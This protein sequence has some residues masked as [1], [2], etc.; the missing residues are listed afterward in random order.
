MI[1]A[2][3]SKN[4]FTFILLWI[5]L[6]LVP[7][8]AQETRGSIGGRVTDSTGAV[9]PGAK[10]VATNTQTNTASETTVTG[11]GNFT[12]LYLLPGAY[13][14]SV[15]AQGF[16]RLVRT[17]IELRVADRV[18]IDLQLELGGVTETVNVSGEA[19]LLEVSSA[20]AGQVIDRRR[21]SELPLA[22]GN[23]LTLI[24]LAPGIVITGGFTSNSALSNSGPSNF[25]SGGSPG[26]NEFTLDGSPNTAD[27]QGNGAA[28]VGL[29]PPTD[30]V[31]EF[32]V[33]TASFDAQQGRTAGA[34]IDVAVRSGTN[35]LHG[36]L[37]EFVRNDKL[38]AN[39][40]FLNR[41]GTPRQTR[42][43]NRFGG[44]VGGPIVLPKIYNGRN[45]TFFFTSYEGIRPITPSLE[46]L[47][48]PTDAF[49][50]GDF[51]SLLNL[52]TPLYVYDPA[53]AR[54][55]GARVVREPIQCN[56]RLNVICP[57][58]LSPVA[59]NYLS[60]LPQP[61]T[62]VGSSTNNFVGN[63]SPI[64]TYNVFLA[65]G[66][67]H[68][69]ERNRLFF[70][71]SQSQR[72][73]LDENSA[74]VN[75]GVRINGR[76]GHRGN[77]GGVFDYVYVPSATTV[78]NLRA[79]MT[80]FKQD[81]FSMSSFDYDVRN[82]GFSEQTLRLFTANTLPQINIGN[83]S[84][85]VE[86]TG[87]LITTPTWSLQ[88]TLT[89]VTGAHAIRAGYDFRVY[90]E[91][92]RDQTF[93]AGQ[94]NFNNDFTR[95]NDQNPSIPLEQNQAQSIAALLLGVPTGGNFPLLADRAAT[96]KYH[97]VFVQDDWK[98]SRRLTLNLGLRYELDLGTTERYNRIVAGFDR[99]AANPAEAAVRANYAL[100][101]I[102]EIAAADFRLPGGLRFADEDD[103][104]A[105]RADRNNFQPRI[106]V[107]YQL[108][109]RTAIRGGW[110]MFM[111]PFV[112]DALNQNG[113]TRSTP[114]IAS[115]DRGLTFQS[116]LANPFPSGYVAEINRGLDSLVGQNPGT[117][118]TGDRKNGMVQRWEVSLQRELPG[119]W[120]VEAA[121]I[122]NRGY[123][124]LTAV[125]ANPIFRQF[126]STSPVRDQA[127]INLL[128][129][130]VTNPFRNVPAFL[131]TNLYTATVI[132]RSQ[133]LRPFPQYTG[134]AEERYDGKS[135]Y[136]AG[137]VRLEKRFSRGYTILGSYAWS[138]YLEE[139]TLLNPTDAAY[140]KRLSEFDS[141]HR[142]AISGIYE[143][144]FGRG[145]AFG[146]NWKGLTEAL[147]GGFQV[148]GIYQFQAG[149]PLTIG[150]VYFNGNLS[151]LD[152]KIAS[153]TIGGVG[154]TN[155]LDNTFQRDIR[156]TGFY[157]TD[158]T[159]RT[160]GQLDVAKQR[161]DAR[162]N[163]GNNIRTLP[164]RASNF[165]DDSISLLDV[166]LIKNFA[167][168][169]RVKLQARAEAINSLNKAHFSGPNINP[170]DIAF[171]RVTNLDGPT[172]PREFQIGLRL[173]F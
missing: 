79:G 61:N 78:F 140:E 108:N 141:P 90:Q 121:Y 45:K 102:P 22:E 103:R 144:P 20:T 114:L 148:Q 86:P 53:T 85:P 57:D 95:L 18:S 139:A 152:M 33:V 87:Y 31:E 64:N 115:P 120:L 163:L 16:K 67:H 4:C 157:F 107:A 8:T 149:R 73:E 161:N 62:N 81:R 119:R 130:P 5:G 164:S 35:E 13:S 36:T 153:D 69:N 134:I 68:I 116:T 37:Y 26:G 88:P 113:F 40:F 92:R 143:L 101:P 151:D 47:T 147:F 58:R 131:G 109:D 128:D 146:S 28:R 127:L 100:N 155:I 123:D 169:E 89:K 15:E 44:T 17:G 136:H 43:Y 112:L 9:V 154:T 2:M 51:S 83:Y 99:G 82:L 46:T 14:V 160:N 60:F 49:R 19:P 93:Q 162:I 132:N 30:A 96:A 75:N 111:V 56:G 48:V 41:E 150:N 50:R 72:E 34:S 25:E 91:N 170:R 158:D 59:R 71:Y 80:R 24:Q 110:A 84:S 94:F 122:G 118:I 52:P 32:K 138:K 66:D 63:A 54:V 129:T 142:V 165:R 77:K 3:G 125:D 104:A 159:V 172:L 6:G 117:V 21:I 137:Q 105:F 124:L 7:V 166:S 12:V 173:I 27:R 10:V 156:E 97:G 74:G 145:R 168:T 65:R 55:D 106:G 11:E 39:S 38:A 1:P 135:S 126:Q 76:V 23:P 171:G 70:R 133:L 29:Q 167:F 98:I 42:R